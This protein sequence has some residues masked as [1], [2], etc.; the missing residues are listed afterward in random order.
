MRTYKELLPPQDTNKV[1][2]PRVEIQN[3]GKQ[4]IKR[5]NGVISLLTEKFSIAQLTLLVS[6]VSPLRSLYRNEVFSGNV[7]MSKV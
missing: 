2:S 7:L 4:K 6:F 1:I 5:L 3:K